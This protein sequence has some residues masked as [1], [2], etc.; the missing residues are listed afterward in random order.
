MAT[1][2]IDSKIS[3]ERAGRIQA[4]VDAGEMASVATITKRP[5]DTSCWLGLW[6]GGSWYPPTDPRCAEL[7]KLR[8]MLPAGEVE[9]KKNQKVM[10][11]EIEIEM[12]YSQYRRP[13]IL[14]RHSVMYKRLDVHFFGTG[15]S[16]KQKNFLP[17]CYLKTDNMVNLNTGGAKKSA[18]TLDEWQAFVDRVDVRV[19]GISEHTVE[20]SSALIKMARDVIAFRRQAP[21]DAEWADEA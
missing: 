4:L 7:G 8:Y 19:S 9:A 12:G 5:S 18:I 6:Y 21:S 15:R 14:V 10:L 17:L 11:G 1:M 13:G 20:M 3:I 2:I 16:G